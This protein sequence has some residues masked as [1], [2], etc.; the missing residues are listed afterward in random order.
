M[1]IE[2]F[3]G[4]Y[5]VP[6]DFGPDMFGSGLRSVSSCAGLHQHPKESIPSH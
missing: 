4:H 3:S 2:R 1:E 6:V 5:S